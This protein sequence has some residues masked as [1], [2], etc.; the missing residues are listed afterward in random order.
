MSSLLR[1][2]HPGPSPINRNESWGAELS[3]EAENPNRNV[4][5]LSSKGTWLFYV[6][7][8]LF[9]QF[10]VS[11]FVPAG[12]AWSIT[13]LL[14]GLTTFFA[15]HWNKGSPVQED[16]G[17]YNDKTLWEQLDGGVPWTAHKKF[18]ISAVV[19]IF[20]VTSHWNNYDPTLLAV[21]GV[22]AGVLIIA[23]L[24]EMHKVR[25]FGINSTPEL[26]E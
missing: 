14:H 22:V 16:Q 20:L 11:F 4:N 1:R 23:K 3:T 8:V 10:V 26:E 21:H 6:F 13:H 18:L 5:W 9:T 19:V 7:A 24:P 12:P 15:F 25:I 17:E 2:R